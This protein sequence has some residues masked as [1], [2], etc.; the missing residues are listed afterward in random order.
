MEEK[1]K[2]AIDILMDKQGL[3]YCEYCEEWV[4]EDNHNHRR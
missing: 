2:K 4:E 3:I 1:Y